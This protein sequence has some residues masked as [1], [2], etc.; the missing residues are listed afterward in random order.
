MAN[1]ENKNRYVG[2]LNRIQYRDKSNSN[3]V[4]IIDTLISLKYKEW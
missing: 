4:M 3:Y 1:N 2:P